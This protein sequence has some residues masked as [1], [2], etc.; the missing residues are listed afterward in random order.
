MGLDRAT[1]A[2]AWVLHV[3]SESSSHKRSKGGQQASRRVEEKETTE[4]SVVL[5]CEGFHGHEGMR[6]GN[7]REF[8]HTVPILFSIPHR[9]TKILIEPTACKSL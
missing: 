9:P 8:W 1:K 7:Q 2:C 4:T 5:G 6:A 3:V